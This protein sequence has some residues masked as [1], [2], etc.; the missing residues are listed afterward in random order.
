MSD[1]NLSTFPKNKFE[2]LTML[3]L[4][5]HG[6]KSLNPEEFLDKYEEVYKRM[7]DHASGDQPP[8]RVSKINI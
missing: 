8:I 2:A 4:E 3:Y 1:I 5:H 6:V 7:K